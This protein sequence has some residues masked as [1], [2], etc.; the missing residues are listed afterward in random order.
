MIISGKVWFAPI[1]TCP[2]HKG[3]MK[4][5]MEIDLYVCSGW[6]GE[7]CEYTLTSEALDWWQLGT[8]DDD[9]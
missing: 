7:G 3:P 8:V 5:L 1:P 9:F 6:D 4:Y 2:V